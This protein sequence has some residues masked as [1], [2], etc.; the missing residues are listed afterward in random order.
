MC[1][2]AE[3]TSFWSRKTQASLNRNRDCIL[4]CM[5]LSSIR[6]QLEVSWWAT[7]GNC[8]CCFL[9]SFIQLRHQLNQ[10]R[11]RVEKEIISGCGINKK[12]KGNTEAFRWTSNKVILECLS[13]L[14]LMHPW[15]I[16][17]RRCWTD[18]YRLFLRKMRRINLLETNSGCTEIPFLFDIK[19]K[20]PNNNC[21]T[22]DAVEFVRL[23][24]ST[25]ASKTHWKDSPLSV[26]LGNKKH[27]INEKVTLITVSWRCCGGV[28][29]VTAAY[30]RT[31]ET[32]S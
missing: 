25:L 28:W 10:Y 16:S 24:V 26:S 11:V 18:S 3:R 20:Y 8:V 9:T 6:S 13:K 7:V 15:I 30:I 31:C 23:S 32:A 21:T 27:C 5:M 2:S 12:V 4:H 17:F 14:H 22:V 29:K 19:Q 1:W